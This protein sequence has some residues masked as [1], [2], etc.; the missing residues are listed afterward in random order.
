[1]IKKVLLKADMLFD[2]NRHTCMH[3]RE[4]CIFL[5]ETSSNE[6]MCMFPGCQDY[7]KRVNNNV[8]PLDKCPFKEAVDAKRKSPGRPKKLVQ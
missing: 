4:K 7:L 8:L 2:E 6:L 1:M 5:Y 3:K